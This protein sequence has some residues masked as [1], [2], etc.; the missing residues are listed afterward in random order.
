MSQLAD[1]DLNR[2]VRVLLKMNLSP[3][4]L[5]E[6]IRL[7]VQQSRSQNQ[8]STPQQRLPSD[9]DSTPV[10]SRANSISSR[11]S[12]E[13][14]S[15]ESNTEES[16]SV[17]K[18]G[19]EKRKRRSKNIDTP[20][21]ML[22]KK[23]CR[24]FLMSRRVLQLLYDDSGRVC[25]FR[26][27][28]ALNQVKGKLSVANRHVLDQERPR[29]MTRCKRVLS[30]GK[31]Y[32]S[33]AAQK[34][35]KLSDAPM[36]HIIDL[37]GSGDDAKMTP[38]DKQFSDAIAAE[39]PGRA[40]MS[41]RAL[42]NKQSENTN[43][44]AVETTK[45]KSTDKSKLAKQF[46]ERMDSLRKRPARG[47]A[48]KKRRVNASS[49]KVNTTTSKKGRYPKRQSARK[50]SENQS[51]ETELEAE[52]PESTPPSRP[53]SEPIPPSRPEPEPTRPES[54]S[55]P[56]S[57]QVTTNFKPGDTVTGQ[58]KGPDHKGEWYA[59]T[60]KSIDFDRETVHI[61]YMDGDEDENLPWTQ[62]RIPG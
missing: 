37:S 59:G 23:I 5:A 40:A 24:E 32:R 11:N 61:V 48:A 53:E 25:N 36:E 9:E 41:R 62:M 8:D 51:T 56:P 22:A 10:M 15:S 45:T 34:G 18:K 28:T 57:L 20:A 17:G 35:H 26:L 54:V 6:G 42:F 3:H 47:K 7:A 39:A 19:K 49:N 38:L 31:N 44:S 50:T 52:E 13:P 27:E 43:K 2:T 55:T 46:R 29:V 30:L 33:K 60:V 58:W 14:G 16:M 12:A 21:A 4:K 1:L